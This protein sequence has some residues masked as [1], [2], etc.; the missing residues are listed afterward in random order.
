MEKLDIEILQL[1]QNQADAAY[2][3]EKLIKATDE[4]ESAQQKRVLLEEEWLKIT[5]ALEE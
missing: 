1:N 2:D 3:A 5:L 4:L